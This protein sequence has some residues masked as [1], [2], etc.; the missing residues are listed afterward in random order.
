MERTD[1]LST[2]Q[3]LESQ[4]GKVGPAMLG[5]IVIV[6]TVVFG[7]TLNMGGCVGVTVEAEEQGLVGINVGVDDE[8]A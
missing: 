2:E 1:T 3:E 7:G 5:G 6:S 4:V 8:K